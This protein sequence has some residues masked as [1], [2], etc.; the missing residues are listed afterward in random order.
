M[1]VYNHEIV[2]RRGEAFTIDKT[3]QNRDGSPYI[4]P[5]MPKP[6]FVVTVSNSL[7]PNENSIVYRNFIDVSSMPMFVDTR[8]VNVLDFT[9][10]DGVTKLYPNGWS[11]LTLGPPGGYVNGELIIYTTSDTSVVPGYDYD[12]PGPLENPDFGSTSDGACDDALFCYTKSDGTTE[13][14][15]WDGRWLDYQCRVVCLIPH[16]DT[17]KWKEGDYYYSIDLIDNRD[18]VANVYPIL[19][20]TKLSVLSNLRG[21][22]I[23]K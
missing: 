5:K 21:G 12:G 2:I 10:P 16:E 1:R 3:I 14:K 4:L 13:Y 8:P 22:T 23:W 20:A 11:D 6:C 18:A 9:Y 7:Y 19:G 17:I 15:R